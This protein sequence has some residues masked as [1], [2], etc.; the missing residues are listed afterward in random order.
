MFTNATKILLHIR[1]FP[2]VDYK[3][4][5]STYDG[6]VHYCSF[7]EHPSKAANKKII[8]HFNSPPRPKHTTTIHH[9]LYYGLGRPDGA[10]RL[11]DVRLLFRI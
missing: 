10:S 6:R 8:N 1:F 7:E 2:P 4:L 11:T 5:C 3:T 9:F